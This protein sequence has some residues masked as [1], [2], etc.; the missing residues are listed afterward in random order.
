MPHDSES[1]S[2]TDNPVTSSAEAQVLTV[3][4]TESAAGKRLDQAL[5]QLCDQYS[6]ARIQQWI[7]SGRVTV[8]NEQRKVK[9]KVYLGECITM[10]V[11]DDIEVVWQAEDIPLDIIYEDDDILVVNKPVG[12]VVHPAPGHA[13]GTLCNG[14]LHHVPN[15]VNLPRA[16]V[17]HRLD[18]DTSGVMVV[19]KTL[20]AHCFLVESLQARE[21]SREYIALVLGEVTAGGTV[22][23]PMGRHRVD[24]K[25][26]AVLSD[27]DTSAKH[28]V[29]H[30]RIR[31]RYHAYTLLDVKLDTGRT[32][33]IR[34]HMAHINFAIVGDPVYGGRMRTPRDCSDELRKAIQGFKRQALHAYQLT[35]THPVTKQEM[36]WQAPLAEDIQQLLSHLDE[37]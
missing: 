20:S 7:K 32:H 33:Q 11:E 14:L 35:L 22:D 19:A 24:R 12:L 34:V 29:T 2:P 3:T 16:G 6:R 8:E 13:S 30:Y 18:K 25:R 5:S 26:M 1:S 17:V 36:S 23:E 27:L 37:K 9:D 28:A 15:A 4:V 31:Q 21:I 10:K